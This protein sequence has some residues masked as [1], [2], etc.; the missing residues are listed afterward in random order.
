MGI[1]EPAGRLR[2]IAACMPSV[3]V[4]ARATVSRG[5]VE[6]IVGAKAKVATVM[7]ELRLVERQ[8]NAL[9]VEI[10]NI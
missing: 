2:R 10:R 1:A 8:Q 4:I 7:I 3:V 6:Q 5:D 9:G